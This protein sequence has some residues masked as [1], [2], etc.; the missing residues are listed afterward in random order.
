MEGKQSTTAIL[1]TQIPDLIIGIKLALIGEEVH[2]YPNDKLS[3]IESDLENEYEILRESDI[4][5]IA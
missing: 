2:M 1:G 3:K 4:N 5:E